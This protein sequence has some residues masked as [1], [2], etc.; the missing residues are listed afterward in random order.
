MALF[1]RCRKL[2]RRGQHSSSI[3]FSEEGQEG[4]PGFLWAGKGGEI[5]P[6]TPM[7]GGGGEEKSAEEGGG[8]REGGAER[9]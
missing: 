2:G 1:P 5:L 3:A 8:G 9:W 7:C 4:D 6:H